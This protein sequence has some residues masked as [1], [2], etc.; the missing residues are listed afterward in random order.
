LRAERPTGHH[1]RLDFSVTSMIFLRRV[2]PTSLRLGVPLFALALGAGAA[3]AAQHDIAGPANSRFGAYVAVLPNGNFVVAAP[4]YRQFA[5]QID[6]VGA[7]YLFA[8]DGRQISRL[9]GS[10][11]RGIVV[12]ANGNVIARGTD[13][14]TWMDGT[15][16]LSGSVSSANSLVGIGANAAVQGL[17][18]GN[19]VVVDPYVTPGGVV[20]WGDGNGGLAGNVA[21]VAAL[22]GNYGDRVGLGGIQELSN[23]N[24]VILSPQAW[25]AG[26]DPPSFRGAV[27][28]ASGT[29]PIVGTPG[30][31]NSLVADTPG[32]TPADLPIVEVADGNYLVV[33]PKWSQGRGAVTFCRG[34]APCSGS[35]SAINSL[36]GSL[37]TDAVGEGGVVALTNGN[38]V[39]D[40][41]SWDG[42]PNTYGRGA[43]TW[44][45]GHA[46]V[47]GIISISNS[48]IGKPGDRVG[49][50]SHSTGIQFGGV[51]ALANGNYV[52]SS[53]S[54]SLVAAGGAGAVTW[55]DGAHG[56][57]GFV[58]SPNSWT[59][60]VSNDT[61]G[62]F[63]T[64][65]SNGNFVVNSPGV[66]NGGG[67]D[68][69]GAVILLAGDAPS[70]GSI[71]PSNSMIGTH[72]CF[73]TALA[74]GNFVLACPA[75]SNSIR[76]AVAWGSGTLGVSGALLD[77]AMVSGD[78]A[79]V[80]GSA[81]YPLPNGNY[82]VCSPGWST[83]RGAATWLDGT[84]PTTGS[85]SA[86]NSLIGTHD[87]DQVCDGGI[88]AAPDSSYVVSSRQWN[89]SDAGGDLS[90]LTRADASGV[91][92][93]VSALNSLVSTA[94]FG[95]L[96][97][98]SVLPDGNFLSVGDS[99]FYGPHV[100]TL[101]YAGGPGTGRITSANTVFAQATSNRLPTGYDAIREVLVVGRP[102][103][104]LVTILDPN[105]LFRD[106][107]E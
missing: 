73:T 105:E 55:G 59:G 12:L 93:P 103:E 13:S 89:H 48:L 63:V 21:S 101:E 76:G 100:V 70:H 104:D 99:Q 96:G 67:L 17:K 95:A 45:D 54:W 66:Y 18:N 91:A 44:G 4:D 6:P 41:P 32:A 79:G 42:S 24:Y 15:A 31:D 84:A 2:L 30:P 14:V 49:L 35:A 72:P 53:P 38:Y 88:A 65:L 5:G 58:D 23:G 1:F 26:G 43:A 74:N 98:A 51:V 22:R 94:A 57:V 82:V 34:D 20:V 27:T 47:H 25:S 71:S 40:S 61:V 33:D 107:F 37:T 80:F 64:P 86:A 28:W 16:G 87:D 68:D 10:G 36:V 8:P 69:D 62:A 56:T 50:V 106:G 83:L 11:Q 9:E 19:Y 81:I 85:V 46:G 39:V 52:V 90:A 60:V 78:A 97:S 29:A 3:S 92:G 102:G 7:V 75:Y 77:H